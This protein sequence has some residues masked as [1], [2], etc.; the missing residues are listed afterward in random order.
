MCIGAEKAG[1]T[2][3]YDNIRHH[4]EVWLPPPL[5]KEL[6]YFDERVP[7]KELLHIDSSSRGGLLK[8]Y[9]PLIS[10][11]NWETL[12]WLWRFN[13]HRN[14][15]M[16]WYLSLF[17][18]GD[19]L[20][21]DITPLY[22]TLDN[23]GVEYARKTVGDQC[24]VFIILRDPVS[25]AW[26]SIKMLYRFRKLDIKQ[27]DEEAITRELQ[28]PFMSLKTDYPRILETWSANFDENN[29]KIFFFDDLIHDK[30]AF[31]RDICRY[32]GIQDH[33]WTSPSL[34]KSSNVDKKKISMP[35]YL[36][37]A[38]SRLYLP[39]LERLSSL[40]GGHSDTWLQKAK[41]AAS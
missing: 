25:Q 13:H 5:Y 6:H 29:F 2:W 32:I 40:I 36:N 41:D 16:H 12:R 9:S 26:S 34:N 19:K 11:P 28:K 38:L 37:S 22:S 35:T 18:K 7:N 4:P 14:N 21:G 10:S 20:C 33:E 8:C 31:L 3:L 17:P 1:T 15:S 30:V 23:R 39:D 27:E 24:K